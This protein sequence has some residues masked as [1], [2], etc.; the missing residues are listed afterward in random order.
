MR[1]TV[2]L[3]PDVER[4]VKDAMRRQDASFKQVLNDS[5]RRALG[6][7]GARPRAPYRQPIFHMGRPLVDLTKANALAAELEDQAIT[8][9]LK[10][11]R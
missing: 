10:A 11:G 1:T 5:L 9:R 3:D 7:A 8:E 2:T 6:A 4:L